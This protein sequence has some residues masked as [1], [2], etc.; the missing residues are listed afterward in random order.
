MI[1]I[2]AIFAKQNE[3]A[4]KAVIGILNG[5]SHAEREAAHGSY[6]NN[7]YGLVQHNAGA[8]HFVLGAFKEAF[9]SDADKSAAFKNIGGVKFPE[10]NINEAQWKQFCSD[11]AAL[12]AA[13]VAFAQTLREE[14]FNKPVKWFSGNPATVPLHFMLDTL[15]THGLHHRGQIS[16]I[17]DELKIDNNFSG[18]DMAFL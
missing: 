1:N 18:V 8:I 16:Q 11:L 9:A 15:I 3:A 13:F 12:D 10:G 5:M 6:Y 17:L 4:D 7:L 14:D 2:Y